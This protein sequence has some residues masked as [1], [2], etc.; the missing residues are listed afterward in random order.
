MPSTLCKRPI[1][2]A[3]GAAV[4]CLANPSLTAAQVITDATRLGAFSGGMRFCEEGYGGDER[5]Y[6][7]ARLRTA[8]VI[9]KL[10]SR[11]K[12][13]AIG[14]RDRA[15]EGGHF[16]G[17]KLDSRECKALLKMSEWKMFVN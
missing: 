14:A 5:R 8:G 9:D 7:F 3:L 10:S 17:N 16:L 2:A 4:I 13:R 11:D 15:Y 12:L 6:R 1:A